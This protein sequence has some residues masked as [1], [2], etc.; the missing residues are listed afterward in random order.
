MEQL[1]FKGVKPKSKFEKELEDAMER[2][3]NS[4]NSYQKYKIEQRERE[5]REKSTL[6]LKMEE[7]R[8]KTYDARNPKD[9]ERILQELEKAKQIISGKKSTT[10]DFPTDIRKIQAQ[11]GI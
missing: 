11:H 9:L 1:E 8:S 2:L 3:K 4:V 6:P 7:P 5:N 10:L